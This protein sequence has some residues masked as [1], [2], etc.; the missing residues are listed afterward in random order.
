ME[1]TKIII[2]QVELTQEDRSLI[3]E[4]YNDLYQLIQ[5]SPLKRKFK[6]IQ[7]LFELIIDD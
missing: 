7:K 6:T 5:K 4:E 3:D 1:V 2:T